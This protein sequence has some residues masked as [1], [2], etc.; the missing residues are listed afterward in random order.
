MAARHCLERAAIATRRALRGGD[1]Q[2]QQFHRGI[3]SGWVDLTGSA[4]ADERVDCLRI[5]LDFISACWRQIG[6]P[7]AVI[8]CSLKSARRSPSLKST[9]SSF[10]IDSQHTR[11]F[12]PQSS[13]RSDRGYSL[14]VLTS[15]FSGHLTER[16]RQGIMMPPKSPIGPLQRRSRGRRHHFARRIR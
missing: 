12:H 5:P 2:K 16:V 14:F 8:E 3:E 9:P 7:P 15:S 13:S 4:V 6:V 10:T 11:R 1:P